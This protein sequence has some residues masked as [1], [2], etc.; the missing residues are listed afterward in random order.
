MCS[1]VI[2]SATSN[3]VRVNT[4][5]SVVTS[6]CINEHHTLEGSVQVVENTCV[7]VFVC[8]LSCCNKYAKTLWVVFV[9][10]KKGQREREGVVG[11]LLI[12]LILKAAGGAFRIYAAATAPPTT[13]T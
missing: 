5:A 3:S 12:R 11:V 1:D 7:C 9:A 13:H 8:L 2:H 4:G 6:T 10:E